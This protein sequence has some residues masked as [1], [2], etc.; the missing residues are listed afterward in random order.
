MYLP[1]NFMFSF[2]SGTVILLLLPGGFWM[3]GLETGT[4][5]L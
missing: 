4:L 1:K 3:S 5:G 2:D